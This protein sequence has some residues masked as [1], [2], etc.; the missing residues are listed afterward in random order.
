[1]YSFHKKDCLERAKKLLVKADEAS[2]RYACLELRQCI[3]SIAYDKLIMYKKFV[4]EDEF[5]RWQPKRVFEFLEQLDPESTKDFTL[6]IIK[7]NQDSSLGKTVFTGH[8]RTLTS[9]HTKKTYNKLGNYLHT[10]TLLQQKDYPK[11]IANLAS[12]LSKIVEDLAHI[13]ESNFDTNIG[14]TYKFKCESC[15]EIIYQRSY[16]L[17]IGKQVKCL[18]SECG[19]LYIV[20]DIQ[21]N[22]ISYKPIQAQISCDCGQTSFINY[23]KLKDNSHITCQCGKVY[24]IKQQWIFVERI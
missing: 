4:P 15:G 12:D 14:S 9:Q 8:H 24:D 2:L 10:P 20:D 7:E 17:E 21:D 1:M 13:V 22:Q 18:K 19:M 11:K 16:G 5:S 23:Y 6:H 3:E